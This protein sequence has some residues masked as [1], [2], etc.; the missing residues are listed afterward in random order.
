[1]L[2]GCDHAPH[3]GTCGF[4]RGAHFG[5]FVVLLVEFKELEYCVVL[6][7]G[8]PCAVLCAVGVAVFGEVGPGG[9]H[10][11]GEF[12][13]AFYPRTPAMLQRFEYV[14]QV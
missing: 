12:P 7:V 1:M 11:F 9:E 2:F 13:V 6:G 3:A 5:L 4:Y 8:L 10:L 14:P